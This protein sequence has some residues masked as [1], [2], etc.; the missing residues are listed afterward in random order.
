MR[1]QRTAVG[2]AL[3]RPLALEVP[4]LLLFFG[5]RLGAGDLQLLK[6]K[7]ELLFT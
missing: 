2:A 4:V 3:L 1:W 6:H 7:I 5:F